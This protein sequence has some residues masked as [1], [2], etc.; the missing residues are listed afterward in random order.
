MAK[1]SNNK[2]QIT[3]KYR[4]QNPKSQKVLILI[5]LIWNLFVF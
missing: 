1:V 2:K 3:I 4:F 5:F